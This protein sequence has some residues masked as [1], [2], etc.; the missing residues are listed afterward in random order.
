[1]GRVGVRALACFWRRGVRA[2]RGEIENRVLSGL[3]DEALR[4]VVLVCL[5]VLPRGRGDPDVP[6]EH[7]P[8]LRPVHLPD[9]VGTCVMATSQA[10][11]CPAARA[12][13][14]HDIALYGATS[15]RRPSCSTTRTGFLRVRPVRHPRVVNR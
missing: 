15:Q 8:G 9:G 11:T 4:R 3:R 14:T 1:M 6:L 7:R 2:D 5:E 10:R 13:C 12:L